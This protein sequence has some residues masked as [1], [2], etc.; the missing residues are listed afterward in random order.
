MIGSGQDFRWWFRQHSN[1][2]LCPVHAL[3]TY[4]A[5]TEQ[6]RSIGNQ[7]VFLG[8]RAPHKA[9]EADSIARDM[10][11]AIRLAGLQG[12]TAKDFRPTGATHAI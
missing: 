10:D 9:L 1:E 11:N 12:Y 7:A 2:L 8:L 4:I 5:R 3:K 6:Y